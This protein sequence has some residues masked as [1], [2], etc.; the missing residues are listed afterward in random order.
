MR[1]AA[2]HCCRVSPDASPV[3]VSKPR[4]IS[5]ET[6]NESECNFTC[7]S[8]PRW[9]I[10]FANVTISFRRSS[11]LAVELK[12]ATAND[13]S[14]TMRRWYKGSAVCVCLAVVSSKKRRK[15]DTYQSH[16]LCKAVEDTEATWGS[17]FFVRYSSV[18]LSFRWDAALQQTVEI[19]DCS[20]G[21]RSVV[22]RVAQHVRVW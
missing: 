14:G 8:G 2:W 19:G 16:T 15:R 10:I 6:P 18:G 5:A 3:K 11:C 1:D 13:I 17:V 21:R 22:T 20:V 12:M 4:Q 7:Q 9:R